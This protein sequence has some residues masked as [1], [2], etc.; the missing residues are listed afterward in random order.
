MGCK[1]EMDPVNP[2][3]KLEVV[4]S[5]DAPNVFVHFRCSYNNKFLKLSESDGVYWISATADEPVEAPDDGDVLSSTL[6]IA[7][8]PEANTVELQHLETQLFVSVF[9]GDGTN[10]DNDG[11]VCAYHNERK[12]ADL[13]E[14]RTW[15]S[16]EEEVK[17]SEAEMEKLKVKTAALLDEYEE[18]AKGEDGEIEMLKERMLSDWVMYQDKLKGKDGEVHNLIDKIRSSLDD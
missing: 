8:F 16:Y 18:K 1:R 5:D 14:F 12:D 11:V 9:S 15:M 3:V 7:Q 4:P 13:F 2:F 17:A 6:F 10:P